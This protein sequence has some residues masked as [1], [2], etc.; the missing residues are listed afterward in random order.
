MITTV[1]KIR[2]LRFSGFKFVAQGQTASSWQSENSA[3]D[4]FVSNIFTFLYYIM[5]LP[6][7]PQHRHTHHSQEKLIYQ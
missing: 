4:L 7:V 3:L 6:R 5:Q 1:S 2:K